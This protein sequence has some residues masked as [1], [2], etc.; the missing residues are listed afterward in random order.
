MN[1][2]TIDQTLKIKEEIDIK[3]NAVKFGI[4]GG[5]VN[6]IISLTLFFAGLQFENWAKWI[7]TLTLVIILILGI[8]SIADENKK[9]LVPFGTLFKAGMISTVIIAVITVIYFLIYS[10]FIETNFIDKVLEVSRQ[11]MAEKGWSEDKIDSAI[12]MSKK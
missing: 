4:I 2:E 9:K 3:T 5:L 10:N 11:Q 6:I 8:K 12:Q 1:N 7:S